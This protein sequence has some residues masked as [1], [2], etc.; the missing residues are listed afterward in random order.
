MFHV[1]SFTS[2]WSWWRS[3]PVCVR[4]RSG[5]DTSLE[6]FE[7][8]LDA[9][10]VVRKEA[11]AERH[12]ARSYG[13]RT[14]RAAPRR[15]RAPLLCASPR[16]RIRPS[17]CGSP[18][19]RRRAPASFPRSRSRDR[20]CARRG[21]GSVV[22]AGRTRAR[23]SASGR[24]RDRAGSD[25]EP[26][27]SSRFEQAFEPL[28]IL[29]RVHRAEEAVVH[30][31]ADLFPRDQ[32]RERLLD[33]LVPRLDLVEH[34]SAHHEEAAVDPDVRSVHRRARRAPCRSS[35]ASTTCAWKCGRT[36]ANITSFP[37]RVELAAKVVEIDV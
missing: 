29:D 37:T 3:S 1:S 18:G 35:S 11:V 6:V 31:Y 27:S 20:R 8:V 36:N 9:P 13:S 2:R 5:C 34:V 7:D 4:T 26:R 17:E 22:S 12:G 32:P 10:A 25:P 14:L 15:S 28:P 30:V 19:P 33:E 16:R 21:R 23:A 24:L